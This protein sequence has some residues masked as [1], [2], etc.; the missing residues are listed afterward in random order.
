MVGF[1]Y[2]RL[3]FTSCD[4]IIKCLEQ[5]ATDFLDSVYSKSPVSKRLKHDNEKL[6]A[7]FGGKRSVNVTVAITITINN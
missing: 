7:S 6:S 1:N 3:N 4:C 2:F 5:E